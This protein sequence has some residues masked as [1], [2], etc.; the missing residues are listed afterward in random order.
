MPESIIQKVSKHKI[1]ELLP[2]LLLLASG[3]FLLYFKFYSQARI[4]PGWDTYSFLINALTFSGQ[5]I[6]YFEFDR[7][8]FV[9]YLVSIVFRMGYVHENVIMIIDCFLTLV[10]AMALYLLL[11]L[12]IPKLPSFVAAFIFLSSRIMVSWEA[13]GYTD[14]ASASM[15]IV[16]VYFFVLGLEKDSK[17]L[18]LF[19]PTY[20]L[21]FLTRSTAGLVIIPILFYYI[22]TQKKIRFVKHH[23]AGIIAAFLVFI[24]VM[25]FYGN[26]TGDPFF[27]IK[28][29]FSGFGKT[30]ETT[31]AIGEI[32]SKSKFFFIDSID[33]QLI[34]ERYFPI[35]ITIVLVGS[36]LN[37]IKYLKHSSKKINSFFILLFYFLIFYYTFKN[38]SFF[39]SEIVLLLLSYSF[40]RFTM[41]TFKDNKAQFYLMFIIWM[42]SYFL[43][44]SNYYQKVT[45]YYIMM[46]PGIAFIIATSAQ[47]LGKTLDSIVKKRYIAYSAVMLLVLLSFSSSAF[48]QISSLEN[49]DEN[50]TV[51]RAKVLGMW[52]EEN[53]ED[54]D[55][56]K[57]YS[58]L[59]VLLGW[60]TKNRVLA[61]PF[62]SDSRAFDHELQKYNINYYATVKSQEFQSCEELYSYEGF[63]LL[64]LVKVDS[65]PK[66]LYIGRNWENYI[67]S[68]TDYEYYIYQ[69]ETKIREGSTY[70]D[71][72]TLDKLMEY[73]FVLLYNFKWNNIEKSQK[74]LMD[75]LNNGGNVIIDCSGNFSSAIHNLEY[76]YF[77]NMLV[78]R[79]SI[80]KNPEIKTFG[81]F[82]GTYEFSGFLSG[83]SPWYGATYTPIEGTDYDV[84]ATADGE[85]LVAKEKIGNGTLMW[86]GYNL[87]YHTFDKGNLSEKEFVKK[88]F[89]LLLEE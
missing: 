36:F 50:I 1:L 41:P 47:E 63:R 49:K 75:Y 10:G 54:L 12:K 33:T 85:I 35:I 42:L 81:K 30:V 19:W 46:M 78:H 14:I 8:P 61:M 43:F 11:R 45:R 68:I 72:Y 40:Y 65:K 89:E 51:I 56:S 22:T 37:I 23:I 9:S 53:I 44:H 82:S 20:L 74:L 29:I 86:V 6:G 66:A 71:D 70:I 79:E 76:T 87:F 7:G 21:A 62:Y 25:I 18:I 57:I 80:A 26:N 2:V 48:F 24:P 28:I 84:L 13:V 32:Y 3:I 16:A 39:F 34:Y 83:T 52:M 15:S 60:Y 58:D 5:G 88:I 77:L 73:D 4:G 38:S 67:E 55:T 17:F 31:G 69:G 64:E 27:Y 59:W